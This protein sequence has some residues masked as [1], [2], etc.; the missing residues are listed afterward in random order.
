MHN[1]SD[2]PLKDRRPSTVV[3]PVSKPLL[4]HS[5]TL[6]F[7]SARRIKLQDADDSDLIEIKMPDRDQRHDDPNGQLMHSPSGRAMPGHRTL[8]RT[9]VV[10]SKDKNQRDSGAQQ[11]VSVEVPYHRTVLP[12]EEV[13]TFKIFRQKEKVLKSVVSNYRCYV[14]DP[15]DCQFLTVVP[16]FN[17]EP[18][19]VY[20]TLR[21]LYRNSQ[22]LY[23]NKDD[24]NPAVVLHALLV[25][26]GYN[27]ASR[28]TLEWVKR[29][30]SVDETVY[31]EDPWHYLAKLRNDKKESSKDINWFL[32]KVEEEQQ[33]R[34]GRSVQAMK[35]PDP[36]WN[37]LEV[38]QWAIN[39]AH[40]S[41]QSALKIFRAGVD[42]EELLH[43]TLS[44]LVDEIGLSL[45]ASIDL[46]KH[47]ERQTTRLE[48]FDE[49]ND[50]GVIFQNTKNGKLFPLQIRDPVLDEKELDG[51]EYENYIHAKTG[52]YCN[53][54]DWEDV[55]RK[56]T[57]FQ[58]CVSLVV[59]C[60]NRQKH[61]SHWWAIQPDI[62]F[63]SQ[64]KAAN[65]IWFTD[66][67]TLFDK[68][69][70]F[71][72]WNILH[73]DKAREY[74]AV[75]GRQRVMNA[76]Q[77]N[78]HNEG[79]IS[80]L[81]R[82]AQRCDFELSFAA[83]VGAFASIG[84]LPV[85]P[86]PCGL[87]RREV[88]E[89]G[90]ALFYHSFLEMK[91]IGVIEANIMIA[92]DR[93]LSV[94]PFFVTEQADG[95]PIKQHMHTT[96]APEATFYFESENNIM[97]LAK[98]R[99]RWI[100]GTIAAYLWF[101]FRK[102]ALIWKYFNIFFINKV[103]LWYLFFVQAWSFFFVFL[104]PAI[105]IVSFEFAISKISFAPNL[106]SAYWWW[107]LVG[108]YV[109]F[110]Y[111]SWAK[112]TADF[113]MY[114]GMLFGMVVEAVTI[115]A[116]IVDIVQTYIPK[117]LEGNATSFAP[118]EDNG[119]IV[120]GDSGYT[121]NLWDTVP[122]A[123]ILLFMFLPVFTAL[124]VS[125]Y[126]FLQ[127]MRSGIFFLAFLPTLVGLF[128]AYS[129]TNFAD[130]SWGNRDSTGAEDKLGAQR[131]IVL[132]HRGQVYGWLFMFL[133]VALVLLASDLI[134]RYKY[135][136]VVAAGFLFLIPI[137]SMFLSFGYWV[138]WRCKWCFKLC[139]GCCHKG[140]RHHHAKA[141]P[142]QI[143]T[144][145]KNNPNSPRKLS[146]MQSLHATI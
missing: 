62:G 18:E 141:A 34:K 9:V 44:V 27:K 97:N 20:G 81:L 143:L 1:D 54:M 99:R 113:A 52:C 47:I 106:M 64:H 100:N 120:L 79:F 43:L 146:E 21:D 139:L 53:C 19:D 45:A 102:P 88:L 101:L 70:L 90:A 109:L 86:G 41:E 105:F 116:L 124:I 36:S 4:N 42:G 115:I 15:F 29:L 123:T 84:V 144:K 107:V 125:P 76:R 127:I 137:T 67:G 68:D 35:N 134:Y 37:A 57:T 26:D 65:F 14:E 48:S 6:N 112:H 132:Q 80:E 89:S 50:I 136:K 12:T 94:S 93:V 129:I 61:N 30:F 33:Q 59:K 128:G 78:N 98:Q 71:Y 85:L 96:V 8:K 38:F 31:G 118:T 82:H 122:L 17:E 121:L 119:A 22:Q 66:C 73:K 49:L 3:S 126:S 133:N 32:N 75:T 95:S 10:A 103:M 2:I 24:E 83:S 11:G 140:S 7:E 131:K 13:R 145:E 55:E 46:M 51:K 91:E 56:L 138:V 28:A 63:L 58:M 39:H 130:F 87:F 110:V 117:Q 104:S 23:G 60:R 142:N 40:M 114:S 74:G 108:L 72:L 5:K 69:C 77:Q 135:F 25:L 111:M 92:E 16:F